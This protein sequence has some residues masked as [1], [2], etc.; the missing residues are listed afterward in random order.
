MPPP[1]NHTTS[2][3]HRQ[4][5]GGRASQGRIRPWHG[6]SGGSISRRG[7]LRRRGWFWARRRPP[8][9]S[10]QQ[11]HQQQEQQQQRPREAVGGG[12]AAAAAA[13]A[14]G[15]LDLCPHHL[16]SG[17]SR[18]AMPASVRAHCLSLLSFRDDDAM[19]WTS[20]VCMCWHFLLERRQLRC[21][22]LTW[23]DSIDSRDAH[24]YRPQG[25]QGQ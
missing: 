20:R 6:G 18:A 5:R 12:I 7:R 14:G 9:S 16:G 25:K 19:R 3:T 17:A 21:V 13:A 8:P 11:L 2:N 24:A 10:W 4:D 22:A 1:T 15:R 23:C